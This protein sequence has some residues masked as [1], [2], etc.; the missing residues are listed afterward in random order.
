MRVWVCGGVGVDVEEVDDGMGG[1]DGMG[2]AWGVAVG[3]YVHNPVL[4]YSNNNS[5]YIQYSQYSQYSANSVCGTS[6]AP[7]KVSVSAAGT[8]TAR[9][10]KLME[11]SANPELAP[12]PKT[13]RNS[14]HQA[15]SR[16]GPNS[17]VLPFFY[18]YH[19]PV[20]DARHDPFLPFVTLCF[21][22]RGELL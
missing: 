15:K 16:P 17:L 2:M 3:V 19:V 18:Y 11:I 13:P 14:H 9:I 22:R 6:L 5:Q 8:L 1:R 12:M 20:F 7:R 21:L 10:V 4:P